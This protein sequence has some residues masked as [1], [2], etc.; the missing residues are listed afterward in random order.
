[1]GHGKVEAPAAINGRGGAG[2]AAP[3]KSR[4]AEDVTCRPREPGS[5]CA[6]G[7]KDLLLKVKV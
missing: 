6:K 1:M 7:F 4:A 3:S 2:I 5:L